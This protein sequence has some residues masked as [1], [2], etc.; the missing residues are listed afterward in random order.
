MRASTRTAEPRILPRSF[1]GWK[2]VVVDLRHEVE[3]DQLPILAAG[4][5]FYAVLAVFPTAIAVVSVYGLFFSPAEVQQHFAAFYRVMPT[6]AAEL[7]RGQLGDLVRERTQ[8]GLGLM[9]SLGALLWTGSSGMSSLLR[10]VNT[11]YC[12]DSERGLVKRR[13]VALMV[14]AGVVGVAVVVLTAAA[15]V[16]VVLDAVGASAGVRSAFGWL[17]WPVLF[18]LVVASLVLL[19]RYAPEGER[20]GRWRRHVP[21]A[22][23]AT[24]L[25]L[26]GSALFGLYAGRYASYNETYGALGAVVVYQLWLWLTAFCVLLGAELNAVLQ[27]RLKDSS[28]RRAG[29]GSRR[30]DPDR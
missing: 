4:L 1:A 16:P 15:V 27:R 29:A 28:P 2:G 5:A 7:V 14:T 24:L 12:R 30:A 25:W 26:A 21:G 8:L 19:Y 3:R 6:A 20:E 10:G 13:A 17:R 18:G 23:V 9:L 22:V 11:A